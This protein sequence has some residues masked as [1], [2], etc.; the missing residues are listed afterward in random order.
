[1]ARPYKRA[2]VPNPE[3]DHGDGDA[4]AWP[5]WRNGQGEGLSVDAFGERPA[6]APALA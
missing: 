5:A 6:P 4:D 3:E 2:A 1:M